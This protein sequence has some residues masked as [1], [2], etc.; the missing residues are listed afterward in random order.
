MSKLN[1]I[2]VIHTKDMLSIRYEKYLYTTDGD[3]NNISFRK[4]VKKYLNDA[5]LEFIN[6]CE[7]R[8]IKWSRFSVDIKRLATDSSRTYKYIY[9]ISENRGY[10][11]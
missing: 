10:Y 2:Q 5:I 9:T 3:I 4:A 7:K 1:N 8:D 11:E 6:E